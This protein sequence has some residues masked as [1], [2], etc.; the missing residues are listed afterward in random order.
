MVKG[1]PWTRVL[2]IISQERAPGKGRDNPVRL[3]KNSSV[4]PDIV[5]IQEN[6]GLEKGRTTTFSAGQDIV[7]TDEGGSAEER[8]GK[9]TA[10][11]T[12]ASISNYLEGR[13]RQR[14]SLLK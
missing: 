5:N 4:F 9:R 12:R 11:M 8:S 13:M 2:Q 14:L 10:V 6:V 1:F 7:G 3:R